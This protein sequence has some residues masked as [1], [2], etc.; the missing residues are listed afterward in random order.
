VNGVSR[1]STLSTL[2]I[3][4]IISI[5]NVVG[6]VGQLRKAYMAPSIGWHEIPSRSLSAEV[7][8]GGMRW[9]S[10]PM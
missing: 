6:V 1:V 10:M 8:Y 7:A 2:S 5:R 3:P 9:S 4:S